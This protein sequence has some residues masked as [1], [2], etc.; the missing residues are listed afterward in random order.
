MK[1][2]ILW[3]NYNE[4]REFKILF[5][6]LKMIKRDKSDNKAIKVYSIKKNDETNCK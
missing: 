2:L 4:L 5:I 3:S 6:L 1:Y